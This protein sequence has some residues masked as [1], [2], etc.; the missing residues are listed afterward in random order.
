MCR[1]R[2]KVDTE[3]QGYVCSLLDR[4]VWRAKMRNCLI[5]FFINVLAVPQKTHNTQ[6]LNALKHLT[7][8][9]C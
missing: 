9:C 7:C 1:E 8:F 3:G 6:K 5:N 4:S 2:N